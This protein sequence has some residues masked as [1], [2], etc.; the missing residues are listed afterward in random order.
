MFLKADFHLFSEIEL[1]HLEFSNAKLIAS[2]PKENVN[3]EFDLEMFVT[4][5]HG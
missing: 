2:L 5:V 1:T 3:E 4:V